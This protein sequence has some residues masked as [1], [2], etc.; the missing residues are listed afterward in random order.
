MAKI[1]PG[2]LTADEKVYIERLRLAEHLSDLIQIDVVDGKFS[3]NITVGA[4][5]IEKYPSS[6]FLEIQLMVLD[7]I[8]YISALGQ[9]EFV[10]R[11]IFPFEITV[12]RNE[13]V[14][15]IKKF[16]KQVGLSL[17]PD[18]PVED[19]YDYFSDLDLLLLM[20]GNPGYSGQALGKDTFKRIKEAKL[21]D[22]TLPLEIDIGVNEEN[23]RQLALAGADFLVTSSAIFNAKDTKVAFDKL[24]M[25]AKVKR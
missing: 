1:V 22:L 6:S 25:L 11:I 20:T 2:I 8:P 14:Y 15:S 23:T 19:A 3:K 10:S 17:N 24:D 12:N 7:P 21:L 13:A 4:E 16:D 9:L 18:T 5:I